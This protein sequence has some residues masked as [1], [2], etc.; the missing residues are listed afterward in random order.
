MSDRTLDRGSLFAPCRP[1]R[2]RLCLL[3]TRQM[4]MF[5]PSATMHKH[6]VWPTDSRAVTQ[7]CHAAN[8]A[9]S[10]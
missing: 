3:C 6:T 4:R 1:P 10:F 2:H 7:D 9:K 5:T 8:D